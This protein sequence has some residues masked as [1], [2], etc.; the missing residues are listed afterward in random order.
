MN[1]DE[2][3]SGDFEVYTKLNPSN[4]LNSSHILEYIS[5]D[6]SSDA[7]QKL[8]KDFNK[9][10][11]ENKLL[12]ERFVKINISKEKLVKTNKNREVKISSSLMIINE[13]LQSEKGKK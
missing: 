8:Q 3:T 9:L 4:I 1:D 2:S 5:E 11:E 6:E 10:Y 7:I 12:K 13:S